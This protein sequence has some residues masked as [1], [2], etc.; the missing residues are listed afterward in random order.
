MTRAHVTSPPGTA[1]GL[2]TV[3]GCGD[4]GFAG[5]G[6][7]AVGARLAFPS[8]VAVDADGNVFLS[9]HA[10]H[11]VRRVD[12]SG[13]IVTVAGDG[14]R[15][16]GGDG[17]EAQRARLGFPVAVALDG[18]GNMFIADEMTHRV[19]RVDASGAIG[20]VAGDGSRGGG[21]DG[22][23]AVRARLDVPCA[24]VAA[25]GGELFVAEGG[26]RAVRRIDGEGTISTVV[27]ESPL[28]RDVAV[29]GAPFVPAGLAIDASGRL[30][31]ADAEGRRLL[32]W[33]ASAGLTVLAGA[34]DEEGAG[35]RVPW[36][37]PC[38]VAVD[39]GGVVY[40]ADQNAHSVW[41]LEG[42]AATVLTGP[43][44]PT[45]PGEDGEPRSELAYPSGLALDAEAKRL[46]VADNFHHRIA[47]V[48][49]PSRKAG[50]RR[51]PARRG[52]AKS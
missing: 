18:Q 47:E 13:V 11:R 15:G 8:G 29:A 44:E 3:A 32:R 41:R 12:P 28:G 16:D 2:P 24:V 51:R 49:L 6:G 39:A 30:Y 43:G 36:A 9:D 50:T 35:V 21:G 42:G 27:A 34:G 38:G 17:G 5:D 33:D 23:P 14:V 45:E 4:A 40:V 22:G 31:I 25:A 37:A 46:L 7:P 1:K 20:T 26:G 52:P 10:N 48:A 19:R